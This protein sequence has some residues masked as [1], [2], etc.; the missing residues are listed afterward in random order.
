[1]PAFDPKYAVAREN[2]AFMPTDRVI[3]V[4]GATG[5][6]GSSLCTMLLA[7][8]FNLRVCSRA[9]EPPDSLAAGVEFVS[10]PSLAEFSDWDAL[11]E[12]VDTVIHLAAVSEAGRHSDQQIFSVNAGATQVLAE[13]AVKLGVRRFIFL[14][15]IKVNGEDSADHPFNFCDPPRPADAYARSK[16][17]AERQL[18]ALTG[19]SGTELVIIR[20]CLVYGPGVQGNLLRLLR[21]VA[22][23]TPLPFYSISNRRSLVAVDNVCDLIRVCIQHPDAAGETFLVADRDP[24]STPD[25]VRLM[26][27]A[28]KKKARLFPVPV[29]VLK[30]AGALLG[31]K[32]EV[33]RLTGNLQLDCTHT[34][35][36]L[37][38]EPQLDT[39]T[40]LTDTVTS[41]L[42]AD[43]DCET[44]D[45]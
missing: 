34:E 22:K 28:M 20:P 1:M 36:V 44:L 9:P 5:F 18:A 32:S 7:S 25:L 35:S 31:R 13:Q 2:T 23:G 11:L 45:D 29:P 17:E 40:A 38:W 19:D 26:A 3:L 30:I 33:R 24:L 21:L 14:S 37:G 42:A 27:S 16:L 10:I 12:N 43:S 6:I 4:T 15:S 41:Y 8:G 39:S